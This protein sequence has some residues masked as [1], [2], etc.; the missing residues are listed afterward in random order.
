MKQTL[1]ITCGIM[2]A[3]L[4]FS[5]T[6]DAEIVSVGTSGVYDESANESNAVDHEATSDVSHQVSLAD[7]TAHVSAAYTANLGGVI[8]FDDVDTSGG[9]VLVS[10]GLRVTYGTSGTKTLNIGITGVA[11]SEHGGVASYHSGGGQWGISSGTYSNR[12][13]AGDPGDSSYIFGVDKKVVEVGLTFMSR[14]DRAFDINVSVTYDN[15]SSSGTVAYTLGAAVGE[16][17][18]FWGFKAP[19]GRFI[20][21]INVD[22][23]EWG[24][25]DDLAFVTVPEPATM[26][27]LGLGFAGMAA[28]RRRRR[29]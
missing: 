17:D 1:A 7:F 19:E 29:A 3:S 25:I 21:N 26:G 8:H 9:N 20:T 27:L 12:L 14:T 5:A 13:N 11:A 6:A 28:L 2:A 16:H 22:H 4:L 10:D 24:S 15:N 23:G 18:T